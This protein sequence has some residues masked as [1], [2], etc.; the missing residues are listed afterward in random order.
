MAEDTKLYH[1]RCEGE[2]EVEKV[3][4][5]FDKMGVRWRDGVEA[6]AFKPP[7]TADE[8]CYIYEIADY[9]WGLGEPCLVWGRSLRNYK[10]KICMSAEEF[11]RMF[12]NNED[13]EVESDISFEELMA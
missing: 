1:I 9:P 13:I 5:I 7:M 4:E 6:S 12:S 11:I 3:I 2:Q 10:D 8:V